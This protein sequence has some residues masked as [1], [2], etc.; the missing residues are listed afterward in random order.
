LDGIVGY[1]I[2]VA[3]QFPTRLKRGTYAELLAGLTVLGVVTPELDAFFVTLKMRH[4]LDTNSH[5]HPV[6]CYGHRKSHLKHNPL[7]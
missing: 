5:L 4:H 3:G 6:G 1:Q 2:T 7:P